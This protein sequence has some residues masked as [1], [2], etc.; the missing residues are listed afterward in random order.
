M[1]ATAKAAAEHLVF[2]NR[3]AAGRRLA[4]RLARCGTPEPVV[5]ALPR[6]G[7]AVAFEVAH[8][9]EAPLRLLAVRK[10]LAPGRP[11]LVI[12]AVAPGAVYLDEE[13]IALVDIP[14]AYVNAAV[15]HERAV[16]RRLLRDFGGDSLPLD[17]EGRTALIVADGIVTGS[18]AL[19]AVAVVRQERAAPRTPARRC[20]PAPTTWSASRASRSSGR[21]RARM[22]TSRPRATKRSAGCSSSRDWSARRATGTRPAPREAAVNRTSTASMRG[23][24]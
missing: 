1:T 12:G 21:W 8:A 22:R 16:A 19:A 14:D 7:V 23:V 20:A 3:C 18:S 6:G 13:T 5:L 2:A 4:A 15:E 17:L 10:I 9:L 11:P 24:A